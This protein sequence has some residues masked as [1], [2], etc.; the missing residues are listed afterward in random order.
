MTIDDDDLTAAD[1]DAL[2]RALALVRASKDPGRRG[3]IERELRE[4]GWFAA[5]HFAVYSCQRRALGLKPWQSPVTV[6][7]MAMR[8]RRA[9]CSGCS[10]P[11]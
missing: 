5:A 3:Q 9:C 8:P 11:A 2:K 4:D 10:M 6:T 7:L 1:R